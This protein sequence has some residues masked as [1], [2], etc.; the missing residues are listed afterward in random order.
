MLIN[1]KDRLPKSHLI[2]GDVRLAA[3][4]CRP[5]ILRPTFTVDA[6]LP[7]AHLMIESYLATS[8]NPDP[9]RKTEIGWPEGGPVQNEHTMGI[10]HDV[11]RNPLPGDQG[12]TASTRGA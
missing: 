11:G 12:Q 9:M 7:P 2:S 3:A 8:R 1:I 4:F 6:D 5:T 10:L